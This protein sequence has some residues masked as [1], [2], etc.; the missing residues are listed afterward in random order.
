[1]MFHKK[2]QNVIE[3]VCI[4]VILPALLLK[5]TSFLSRSLFRTISVPRPL[6]LE[7][8]SK[9]GDWSSLCE[10]LSIS[11]H[12]HVD[13]PLPFCRFVQSTHTHTHTGSVL[14]HGDR[15]SY[16][17]L[18]SS[19]LPPSRSPSLSVILHSLLSVFI[20]KTGGERESI[21]PQCRSPWPVGRLVSEAW[22]HLLGPRDAQAHTQPPS[23]WIENVINIQTVHRVWGTR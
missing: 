17:L 1:M 23:G 20:Q 22:N 21:F 2:S 10:T 7:S 14:F 18:W 12:T 11:Q 4:F 8:G 5:S 6:L 13:L 19:L 16:F 3:N 9:V 15:G